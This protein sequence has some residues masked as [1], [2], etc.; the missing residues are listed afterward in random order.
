M[1]PFIRTPATRTA[2]TAL[3]RTGRPARAFPNATFA[4]LP[5]ISPKEVRGRKT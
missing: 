2:L 1:R 3:I 4:D 5:V